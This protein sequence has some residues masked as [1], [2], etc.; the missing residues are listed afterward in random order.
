M[1]GQLILGAT[2]LGNPSD[3]SPRLREA[4]ASVDIV[5]AEDTRRL[6]RLSHD[7]GVTV[8]G[9][10]VSLHDAVEQSRSAGLLDELRAGRS[11][12]VVSDAGMPMVSDPGFR[13]V[14]LAI[15]QGITVSVLPGPSAV[16]AALVVSG[17]PVDRF[18]FEG[19]LPRRGGERRR[20]IERL[21]RDERTTVYFEAPHRVADTLAD[22]CE[23]LGPDRPAALCRELTKTYEEIRRGTLSELLEGIEGVRGEITLVVGGAPAAV[24]AGDEKDWIA[25]VEA[26]VHAGADRRTAVAET[27]EA[28][29]L[30]KRAVY[31]AVVRAKHAA[32]ADPRV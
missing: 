23:V 19:F 15:E 25:E 3:A 7:L 1:T 10:L 16:L 28:R 9:R 22:M 26:R 30:P 18:C 31:D 32:D 12:L 20:R 29:G 13:L 6:R 8:S 21:A 14:S 4:L 11:V 27:A 2:P 17:L 24:D 5:A